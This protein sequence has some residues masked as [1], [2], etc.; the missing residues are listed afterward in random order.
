[1]TAD[2]SKRRPVEPNVFTGVEGIDTSDSF[3]SEA[4]LRDEDG[5]EGKPTTRRVKKKT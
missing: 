1:M 2:G 5:L 4:R 3:F